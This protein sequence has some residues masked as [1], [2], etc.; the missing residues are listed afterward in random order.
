[1][2]TTLVRRHFIVLVSPGGDV[3]TRF[4]GSGL[5]RTYERFYEPLFERLRELG[6]E[7]G[8]QAQTK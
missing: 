4:G 8:R 1:M 7:E 5:L 3:P 6:Y 2:P